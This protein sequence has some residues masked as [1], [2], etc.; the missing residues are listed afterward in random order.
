[1]PKIDETQRLSLVFNSNRREIFVAPYGVTLKLNNVDW[2]WIEFEMKCGDMFK[3]WHWVLV[4]LKD[5]L[6]NY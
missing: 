5:E 4:T 3:V 2:N 6:K 1:M